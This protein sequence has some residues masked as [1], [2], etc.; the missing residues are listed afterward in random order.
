MGQKQMIASTVVARVLPHIRRTHTCVERTPDKRGRTVYLQVAIFR[1]A[2]HCI[3]TRLPNERQLTVNF[4]HDQ[5][6]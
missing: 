2:Y 4:T 1:N 3:S 6:L 5:A